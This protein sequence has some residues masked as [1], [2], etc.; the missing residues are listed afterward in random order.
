MTVRTST[1]MRNAVANVRETTIGTSPIL[2]YYTG[3]SP[4]SCAAS[5]TGTMILE[6]TLPSDFLGN[7]SGG[8]KSLAGTWTGTVSNG[9]GVPGYCRIY[10]SDGTTCHEQFDIPDDATIDSPLI[11]G[12]TVNVTSASFTEGNA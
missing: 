9:G 1:T 6:C 8:A 5:A 12:R 11:D 7:A 4:A 3:S 10:A 2:R